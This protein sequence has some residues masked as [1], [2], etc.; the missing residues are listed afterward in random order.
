VDDNALEEEIWED[1]DNRN[2]YNFSNIYML[3]DVQSDDKVG[4]VK[5]IVNFIDHNKLDAIVMDCHYDNWIVASV[6]MRCA[7]LLPDITNL[8]NYKGKGVGLFNLADGGYSKYVRFV[9]TV[10][11][12][13][14]TLSQINRMGKRFFSI[15]DIQPTT[16]KVYPSARV[17]NKMVVTDMGRKSYRISDLK[18]RAC[19]YIA[20]LRNTMYGGESFALKDIKYKYMQWFFAVRLARIKN[21]YISQFVQYDK[22]LGYRE[23]VP[24]PI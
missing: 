21:D 10:D 3:S 6:A 8:P 9:H 23:Y 13:K 16:L 20:H 18:K 5:D 4:S 14:L 7:V 2:S 15:V 19:S 11:K 24:F 22:G 12:T 17:R 1:L